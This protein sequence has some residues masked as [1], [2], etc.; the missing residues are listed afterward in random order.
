M[1]FDKLSK[2]QQVLT[3]MR[4]VLS[5]IVKEITPPPGAKYPLSE[6]TVEDIRMCLGLITN[7][8]QELSAEQG[9]ENSKNQRPYYVDEKK[10]H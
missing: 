1:D 3:V 8:E 7:R 4:K 2:E 6:S 9:D 10:P 5:N